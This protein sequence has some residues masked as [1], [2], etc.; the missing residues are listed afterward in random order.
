MKASPT[1]TQ[2]FAVLVVEDGRARISRFHIDVCGETLWEVGPEGL[3][4]RL[5]AVR[6]SLIAVMG[7]RGTAEGLAAELRR[8]GVADSV[9][10]VSA[11]APTIP[12]QPGQVPVALPL[13]VTAESPQELLQAL[14]EALV[15]AFA[16]FPVSPL[17]GMPCSPALRQD[18][19]DRLARGEPFAFLHLDLDNFKAYNDLYG[20][21]RGDIAIRALGRE[22]ETALAQRG[23]SGS[24]AAHIGGD[25]FAVVTAPD[26]AAQVARQII[27]EFGRKAPRLYPKEAQEAGYVETLDR[28]GKPT[29]YPL[30]TVS[31]GGVNTLQRP[32]TSYLQLT[33]LAAEMKAYAKS[34]AGG[35]FA[36]D[37]RGR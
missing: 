17:T 15:S 31:V 13:E 3:A 28:Q 20:F 27:R 5:A 4:Q 25:D 22:V 14:V 32:I 8:R 16:Q 30:M 9:F 2:S 37:R 6:P 33:E 10:L 12:S 24:L 19:E 1:T 36:M 11:A 26:R 23:T 35:R 7:E 34:G 18:V 29:R 21:G